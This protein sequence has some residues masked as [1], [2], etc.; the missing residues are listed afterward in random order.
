MA[1]VAPPQ[2]RGIKAIA[3]ADC[4]QQPS[5]PTTSG[6]LTAGRLTG[7]AASPA[8]EEQGIVWVRTQVAIVR[9]LIDEL[10]Q[11]LPDPHGSAVRA[12]VAEELVRLGSRLLQ[13][14][15]GLAMCGEPST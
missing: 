11:L 7:N 8:Q 12:Q 1:S 14:A 5:A 4:E 10:D 2:P 13:L 15:G 3:R 9:T 6:A